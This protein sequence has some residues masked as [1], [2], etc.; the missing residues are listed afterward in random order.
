M[1]EAPYVSGADG[2]GGNVYDTARE[3]TT[4][5]NPTAPTDRTIRDRAHIQQALPPSTGVFL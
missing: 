4:P 5:K 3:N 2:A 1:R